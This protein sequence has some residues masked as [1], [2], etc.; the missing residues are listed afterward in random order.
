MRDQTERRETLEGEHRRGRGG[1]GR[2]RPDL[3]DPLLA[4]ATAVASR[5]QTRVGILQWASGGLLFF[6]GIS[7]LWQFGVAG[8]WLMEMHERNA[9]RHY[10]VLAMEAVPKLNLAASVSL[11]GVLY[12]VCSSA[13]ITYNNYLI[14]DG[15]FPFAANLAFGHQVCGS[16]FLLVLYKICP[17][18]YPSLVEPEKRANCFTFRFLLK[19]GLP[20]ASCF[21]MQL[22]LSNVAYL[23]ASVAFLQMMKEGNM[24]LVYLL[25]LLAGLERFH[26]IQA[27]VLFCLLASTLLTIEGEL[28]VS[29]RA[30]L[31]QGGS[32]LLEATK[33]VAQSS[34]LSAAGSAKLDALSYNL[35]IQPLSAV[36]LLIFVLSCM[37]FIP[38]VP[39]A[40]WADYVAWW[41]HLVGNA[42]AAL[43]LNV[44][45]AL[46]ISKTSAIGYIVVG[47]LK[48]IVLVVSDV[49][50]SGTRISELQ[51][52]AFSLQILFVAHYSFFKSFAKQWEELHR[53]SKVRTPS[54]AAGKGWC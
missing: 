10:S 36:G 3:V 30:L 28:Q 12:I 40:T 52:A 50:F 43:V 13:F 26:G 47:I 34:L 23:Y 53:W 25:S 5:G 1:Q 42:C 35:L 22:V 7:L 31:V 2:P 54:M 49:V 9:I 29:P 48:D 33:I 4:S 27:A 17:F 20:I 46:F 51:I 39:T 19:G 24:V 21:S 41:P 14:S 15:R 37:A 6:L 11:Y 8:R 16:L 38:G 18:L 32:Q 45:V 44:A